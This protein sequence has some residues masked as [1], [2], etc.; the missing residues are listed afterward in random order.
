MSRP[1]ESTEEQVER[2]P[3]HARLLIARLQRE[4]A[5]AQKH[6]AEVEAELNASTVPN[7]P[8]QYNRPTDI[9]QRPLPPR[10]YLH[11]R[12]GVGWVRVMIQESRDGEPYLDINAD[13]SLYVAPTA[14]N[15]IRIRHVER[16]SS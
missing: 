5:D 7:S 6:V 8:V 9:R 3:Q 1:E 14:T 11:F 13:Q 4:L 12:V 15:S 10:A 16:F 2:L